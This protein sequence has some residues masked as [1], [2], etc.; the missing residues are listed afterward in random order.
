MKVHVDV[1]FIE[2]L[3]SENI[4]GHFDKTHGIPIPKY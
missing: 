3:D 2:C 1:K 4:L